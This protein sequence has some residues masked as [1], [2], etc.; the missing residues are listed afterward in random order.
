LG[1]EEQKMLETVSG[2]PFKTIADTAG[3][4]I[5]VGDADIVLNAVSRKSGPLQMGVNEFNPQYVFANREFFLNSMEYLT[6][7]APIMDTRNKE[8]TLRLLDAQKVK[9]GRTK[10]QIIA[11]AVPIGAILLFAMVFQFIR[12]R[13]YAG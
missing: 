10:W 11:F 12:Q 1:T 5:V 4:M 6:S 8:L 7:K 2:K 9:A 3:K 13:K